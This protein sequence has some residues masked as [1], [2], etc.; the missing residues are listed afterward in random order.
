MCADAIARVRAVSRSLVC[1]KLPLPDEYGSGN[2]AGTNRSLVRTGTLNCARCGQPIEP[3]Q[4][5]H[6]DHS[7]DRSRY[8][9]A[10]HKGCNLQAAANKTNGN[11]RGLLPV[12]RRWSHR[13][14]DT[15]EPGTIVF[16]G[17]D[18]VDYYTGT[19]WRPVSTHDL[20]LHPN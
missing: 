7:D 2:S 10:S 20:A 19:E 5:W 8:I 11:R 6:L 18:T 9:G 12:S 3:G 15:A 1:A 16:N 4:Q 13:W 17:T 14:S